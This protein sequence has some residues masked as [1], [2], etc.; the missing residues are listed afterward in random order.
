[1]PTAAVGICEGGAFVLR[2]QESAQSFETVGGH[3]SLS[4]ELAQRLL[5]AR[6]KE[7]GFLDEFSE[8]K[9]AFSRES[10]QNNLS[11]GR[12]VRRRRSGERKPVGEVFAFEY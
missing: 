10:L 6:R 3:P 8:K 9:R 4:A 11:V 7:S 1:M 5:D 2:H 12:I